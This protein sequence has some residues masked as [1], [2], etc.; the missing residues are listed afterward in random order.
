MS[1]AT[2]N[3]IGEKVSDK[4]SV[5]AKSEK[6]E[7]PAVESAE[8]TAPVIIAGV[9]IES[10]VEPGTGYSPERGKWTKVLSQMK[11]G[12]C[13]KVKRGLYPGIHS[14]AKK[15]G[16]TI[17]MEAIEAP[18]KSEEEKSQ[19]Q[20]RVFKM[21]EANGANLPAIARQAAA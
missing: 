18:G 7:S 13:F 8:T 5:V 12:Q 15:L 10:G 19:Q 20:I 16:V 11:P 17:K 14:C 1:K 3:K 21:A 9:E 4:V 6:N 2:K